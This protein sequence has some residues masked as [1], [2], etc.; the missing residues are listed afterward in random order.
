[1][2]TRLAERF[3]ELSPQLQVSSQAGF[4][5]PE[6]CDH[7]AHQQRPCG[8]LFSLPFSSA[9]VLQAKGSSQAQTSPRS[10]AAGTPCFA[11]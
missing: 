9:P 11:P 10:R 5:S 4:L 6:R 1:M 7:D 8:S 3:P 2:R